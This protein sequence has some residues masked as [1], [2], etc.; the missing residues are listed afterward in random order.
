[1]AFG[2]T[3]RNGNED[4]GKRREREVHQALLEGRG[5]EV[6][7]L[8]RI[9]APPGVHVVDHLLDTWLPRAERPLVRRARPA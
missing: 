8:H 7:D 1:M 6:E 3:P 5:A 4:T 9:D 2:H